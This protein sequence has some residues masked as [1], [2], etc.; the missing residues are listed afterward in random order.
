[1]TDPLVLVLDDDPSIR[2]ALINL[3]QSVG[4]E[5]RAFASAA[6]FADFALPDRP[7]CLVLDVRMP[8]RNGLDVQDDVR[9]RH[10]DLPVVFIT[11]H[12]DIPMSVRAMKAGAIEF[13]TKPFR[14]QDLLDAI[15]AGL[16]RS[17]ASRDRTGALAALRA[18]HATLS[19]REREVMALIVA[20]QLTKQIAARLGLS[21]ITVKVC[22]AALMKKMEAASLVE[23]GALAE[24][25]AQ[26]DSDI[27]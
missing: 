11:A 22:R 21:E 8:E 6:E 9:R 26:G 16:A 19:A 5:A 23:L 27:C 24:R 20:G 13:L 4:L 14:E 12:G 15:H 18:R 1:M 25:L 10:P 2:K 7:A 17:R 3:L